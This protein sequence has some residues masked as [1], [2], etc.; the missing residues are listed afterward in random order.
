MENNFYFYINLLIFNYLKLLEMINLAIVILIIMLKKE[1]IQTVYN[2]L[3]IINNFFGA[4]SRFP[5]S[6]FSG[7]R[8]GGLG[9]PEPPKNLQK[10]KDKAGG[11]R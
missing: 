11:R 8:G 6:L 1:E 3:V 7:F 4:I 5:H 10:N 9:P 2:S